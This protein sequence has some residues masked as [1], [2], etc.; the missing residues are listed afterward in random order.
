[1]KSKNNNLSKSKIAKT[2]IALA[3]SGLMSMGAQMASA[4]VY[5]LGSANIVVGGTT[6][7]P[8]SSTI[9][10]SGLPDSVQIFYYDD[11]GVN[12]TN[13][14]ITTSISLAGNT[15][16]TGATG[17]GSDKLAIVS[18]R[19][20]DGGGETDIPSLSATTLTLYGNNSITGIVGGYW[21][22]ATPATPDPL[23]AI[24]IIGANNSFAGGAVYAQ[25]IN[26]FQGSSVQFIG[27]PVQGN[28]HIGGVSSKR[29]KC[30]AEVFS[31]FS[32]SRS[33]SAIA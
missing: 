31:S 28:A 2:A 1:M 13:Q 3:V 8:T 16:L 18:R 22:D 12:D 32:R 25:N 14:V 23:S 4:D 26:L 7:G 20:E 19:V 33:S 24:N 17:T 15:F 11:D 29:T 5:N 9:L 21:S 27:D 10:L 6:Y 30:T